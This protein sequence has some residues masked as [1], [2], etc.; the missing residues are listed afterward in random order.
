MKPVRT[1]VLVADGARA[2]I[3]LNEGPGKGLAPTS[4]KDFSAPNAPTRDQGTDRPGR[5]HDRKGQG[6]HA[7]EPRVDWHLFDKK[8]FAQELATSVNAAALKG[9]FDKLVLV[10]PPKT[11][12]DLRGGLNQQAAEKVSAEIPKDYTHVTP[13]ELQDHLSNL[14]VL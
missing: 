14:I 9:S 6:R 10:A 5:V 2:R 12:G 11:L 7:M 3:L 4:I 13:K 8:K 1:W